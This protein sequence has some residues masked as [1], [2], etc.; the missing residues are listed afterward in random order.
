MDF[1]NGKEKQAMKMGNMILNDILLWMQKVILSF[2]LSWCSTIQIPRVRQRTNGW[3]HRE[4]WAGQAQTHGKC[5]GPYPALCPGDQ[6]V[7]PSMGRSSP[8]I[9]ITSVTGSFMDTHQAYYLSP[10]AMRGNMTI[11]VPAS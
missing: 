11:M 8:D 2:S 9:T 1:L 3:F 10:G 6:M 7:I 5:L 4:Q